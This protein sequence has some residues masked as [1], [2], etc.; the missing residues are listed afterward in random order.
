MLDRPALSIRHPSRR[1]QMYRLV[2]F[3]IRRLFNAL[4]TYHK[5]SSTIASDSRTKAISGRGALSVHKRPVINRNAGENVNNHGVSNVSFTIGVEPEITDEREKTIENDCRCQ[6]FAPLSPM[7]VMM[8]PITSSVRK[9]SQRAR[10]S[11]ITLF[12][13]DACLFAC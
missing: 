12:Y 9:V 6:G 13:V 7:M 11:F 1:F 5:S 3:V 8:I 2:R 10:A 4:K